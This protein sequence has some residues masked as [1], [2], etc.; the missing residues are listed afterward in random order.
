MYNTLSF[1]L[2]ILPHRK[3]NTQKLWDSRT[4]EKNMRFEMW[5]NFLNYNSM[6]KKF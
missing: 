1:E 3:Y 5:L 2:N 4:R 6:D